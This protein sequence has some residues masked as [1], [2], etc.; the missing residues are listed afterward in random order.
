MY[1]HEF[2]YEHELD[3][4]FENGKFLLKLDDL[5]AIEVPEKFGVQLGD[6]IYEVIE[7]STKKERNRV[8][9]L[10]L[11]QI[12]GGDCSEETVEVLTKL[13]DG[14]LEDD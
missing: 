7:D 3:V 9:N 11:Q 8:A 1:H 2:D 14:I 13:I 4:Y 6:L 10:C 12:N 5:P